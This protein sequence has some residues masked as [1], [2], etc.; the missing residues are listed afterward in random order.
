MSNQ[1]QAEKNSVQVHS[2]IGDIPKQDWNRLAGDNPFVSHEF[3]HALETA[4]CVTRESGWDPRHLA[5]Y[6]NNQ[7]VGAMPLYL[8][9]HS[10]GEYIFDW[11]W[12]D[13]Y[14]RSGLKYYPKLLCAVPFTP[15]TGP[16]LLAETAAR[17]NSLLLGA[18]AL[19]HEMNVSSFHCLLPEEDQAIEMDHQG[20]M[21]RDSIQFHWRNGGYGHFDD[22]LASM[23]H[24]KRKKIKQERRKVAEAG[25]V[26]RWLRGADIT[27]HDW[28]FFT[29]CYDH[30]YH[31]HRS[32]PYLNREF[33]GRIGDT[34][35]QNILLIIAERAGKAIGAALNI[36]NEHHLYG[37]YWG[38]L[39][40]IPGLHFEACYYQAIAFCI[41][42][43][44]AVFEGGA[45][46]EHKLARGLLPVK[47]SS[48]HW[49]AHPEFSK[50]IE[51]YLQRES[52]GIEK[53][54]D[55]LNDSSPFKAADA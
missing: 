3:L 11:A 31:M 33:F 2:S 1:N 55:E 10:Y 6:E 7:L 39:E 37:R 43:K 32:T 38:A 22:F 44:I 54:I 8:K 25:V 36:H 15:V 29:R 19:A 4:G 40:Y 20:L 14:Q 21:R 50:A 30:T 27:S 51:N 16:R 45:Q 41:A 23:S 12:A 49:L 17:R 34:M 18:L 26:F 35:P 53:Y 52:G 46:G 42:Q 5:L 24:D 47:T 13:A 28:N 48:S 9:F